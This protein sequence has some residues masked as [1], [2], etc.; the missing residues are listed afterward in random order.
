MNRTV[1]SVSLH[2][3]DIISPMPAAGFNPSQW[4][5]DTDKTQL[6]FTQTPKLPLLLLLQGPSISF[7]VK[8]K[9]SHFV[10]TSSVSSSQIIDLPER[11]QQHTHTQTDRRSDRPGNRS[12]KILHSSDEGDPTKYLSQTEVGALQG[13]RGVHCHA[14]HQ[15]PHGLEIGFQSAHWLHCL[16]DI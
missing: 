7:N 6:R 16:W 11:L 9:S 15:F 10:Q 4:N 12:S 13:Q 14:T 8:K 2:M 1:Q 5:P 3:L